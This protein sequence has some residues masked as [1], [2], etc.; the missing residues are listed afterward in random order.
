MI[1]NGVIAL[2][3]IAI[4]ALGTAIFLQ[5]REL[6]MVTEKLDTMSESMMEA[7]DM[8]DD[9][10]MKMEEMSDKME[11]DKMMMEEVS[12]RT[13]LTLF[14]ANEM[15]EVLLPRELNWN[16]DLNLSTAKV[17]NVSVNGGIL[18]IPYHD[19]WGDD[20][21]MVT[22]HDEKDGQISFGPLFLSELHSAFRE[23]LFT[24]AAKRSQEA[25]LADEGYV[26]TNCRSEQNPLPEIV[27]VGEYT[28]VKFQGEHCEGGWVGYEIFGEDA[29]YK[30]Q[31]SPQANDELLRWVIERSDLK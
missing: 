19:E 14:A 26:T 21:Y 20:T 25:A 13:E 6:A 8:M 18:V 16:Y 24:K 10:M 22:S 5:G 11:E 31:S 7:S 4:I 17:R 28:A 12:T 9:A 29:N 15:L 1:Q 30:F 2:F 23:G 3:A 27:T